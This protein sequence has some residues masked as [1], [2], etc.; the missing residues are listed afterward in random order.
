MA[1]ETPSARFETMEGN[2]Y[3]LIS[4]NA[5]HKSTPDYSIIFRVKITSV[6]CNKIRSRHNERHNGQWSRAAV[7]SQ[8]GKRLF[9]SQ[10]SLGMFY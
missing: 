10:F 6:Y 5:V 1:Q 4:D 8:F 3:D 9:W 2:R 7:D